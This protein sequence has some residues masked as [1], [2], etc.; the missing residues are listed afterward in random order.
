[1]PN[2]PT[3]SALDSR[4]RCFIVEDSPII[5][6]NLTDTLEQVVPVDVVGTSEDEEGA[7]RWLQAA[8]CPFDLMIVD[9]FLKQGVGLNVLVRARALTPSA[10]KVVLTNYATDDTRQRCLA[11]GAER[12]FDKSSEL[13]DLIAYC[14]ELAQAK[15]KALTGSSRS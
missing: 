6:K 14:T 3:P 4:L 7:V 13:E 1:V 2:A 15:A 5:L 11:L 12:V 10:H 8:Q 9:I